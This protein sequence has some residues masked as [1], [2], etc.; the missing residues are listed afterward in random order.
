MKKLITCIL[1][2]CICV[3][4]FGCKSKQ[5]LT[6][7]VPY[8]Y[9][10]MELSYEGSGSVIAAEQRES[11]GHEND[12]GYLLS[13]FLKG[14]ESS[15]FSRTFPLGTQL[16]SFEHSDLEAHIVLTDIFAGLT[17]MDLTIACACIT[18]TVI[19]LTGVQTVHIRTESQLLNNMQTITMDKSSLVLF[20]SSAAND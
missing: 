13:Q 11:R 8:Y 2:L 20:D 19:E 16:I 5:A 12:I 4:F 1:L 7:P 18:M 9:R 10:R 17:G 6:S 3:S 15:A 14:P